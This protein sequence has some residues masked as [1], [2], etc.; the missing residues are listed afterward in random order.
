[1]HGGADETPAVSADVEA[2]PALGELF[3]RLV[4]E[5]RAMVDA[6]IALYRAEAIK[7]GLTAGVAAGLMI[8]ALTLAQGAL[9]ATLVGL[10]LW[11]APV[12]GTGFSIVAV[13]SAALVIAAL[14]AWLGFRQ[15]GRMVD[16]DADR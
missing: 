12:I 6:E 14:L 7:R 13:V 8:G 11:L 9:I 4:D 1:V 10:I 16:P 15:I 2:R 3:A 5:L